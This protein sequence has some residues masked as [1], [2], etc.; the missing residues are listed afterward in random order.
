M[1]REIGLLDQD[2]GGRTGKVVSMK[3]FG[4]LRAHD[5]HPRADVGTGIRMLGRADGRFVAA[6]IWFAVVVAL[7]VSP[8]SGVFGIP[9]Q[10]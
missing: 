8:F 1:M 4:S 6:V 2:S 9:D 7:V 5:T 10:R 3:K